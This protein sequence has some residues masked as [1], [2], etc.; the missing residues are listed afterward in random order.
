[1]RRLE[2]ERAATEGLGNVKK[3][4]IRVF[5]CT[6]VLPFSALEK[7][8]E[9]FERQEKL[10]AGR[11]TGASWEDISGKRNEAPLSASHADAES[12]LGFQ[13]E[14]GVRRASYVAPY[15]A[16]TWRLLTALLKP[17]AIPNSCSR[18]EGAP[19]EAELTAKAS[20]ACARAA[21][22]NAA[23]LERRRQVRVMDWLLREGRSVVRSFL[24]KSLSK[25][26][27]ALQKDALATQALASSPPPF[28]ACSARA[29]AEAR[30]TK[31]ELRRFVVAFHLLS[32]GEVRT[33]CSSSS[34]QPSAYSKAR[35]L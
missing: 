23:V 6:Y 4:R 24:A 35:R 19:S 5:V 15:A 28:L 29:L 7:V 26:S 32:V 31:G 27:E 13:V 8:G 10:Y 30:S 22:S 17:E 20:N 14:A 2:L 21:P 34:N 1:M 11:A 33:A 9:V 3:E 18:G 16:Q 12:T 25:D